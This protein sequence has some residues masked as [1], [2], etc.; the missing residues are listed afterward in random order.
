MVFRR[1]QPRSRESHADCKGFV[2][3]ISQPS[4]VS[5]ETGHAVL[6]SAMPASAMAAD[7]L[8]G[9]GDHR[10]FQQR[11]A[12]AVLEAQ[13]R[14]E[15]LSL[16]IVDIDR[17]KF[18][19]DCF[20]YAEGDEM[21]LD[22]ARILGA[23]APGG[24]AFRIGGDEF[25]VV[26]P[27]LGAAAA[28]ASIERCVSTAGARDV[29]ST[30]TAGVATLCDA[31]AGD[32]AVLTERATGAM[33]EAKRSAR[34]MVVSFES[35]ADIVTVITAAKVSA[36][37]AML[38]ERRLEIAFQPIWDL[39][40]DCL[41]GV[42]AL[43]RPWPGYGF[44]GPAEMF[45]IA[46]KLGRAHE[47]DLICI[48][49]TLSRATQAPRGALLFL[50]INPQALVHDV[51]TPEWLLAQ[52]VNNGLRPDQV[53]LEITE[54]SDARLDVV[55]DHATAL[56]KLGF[57][58][59]LDDVGAGN[60]GIAML[61][62][63]PVDF[64]KI[65]RSV[66]SKVLTSEQ[67]RAVFISLALFAYRVGAFVITEGIETQDVFAFVTNA[68]HLNIMRDP[69]I[70]AVQGFLFGKPSADIRHLPASAA[71]AMSK[72]LKLLDDAARSLPVPAAA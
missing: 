62:D 33:Q 72:Q 69:P 1:A 22:L 71:D 56:A 14:D 10:A 8:T 51:V 67:A 4:S 65:D 29:A 27:R 31:D 44:S 35:V 24:A 39:E 18:F 46:E 37:Y 26:M 66:I 12:E 47:L 15:D 58:L 28:A 48:E 36:L 61:C 23:A 43:A 9:L 70:K 13:T 60:A 16:A 59:A 49:A 21:L 40:R 42:E 34:G 45:D 25:V 32:A 30:I 20:G 38:E 63:L 52:V 64:L 57:K 5:S 53:V 41:L 54:R 19:N 68:H 6:A 17:L 2:P 50:N 3:I 7:P 11:L 55:V